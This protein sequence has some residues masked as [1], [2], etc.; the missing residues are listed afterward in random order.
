MILL[1][2]ARDA[3]LPL[4]NKQTLP[5]WEGLIPGWTDPAW[6]SPGWRDF[7]TPCCH[8]QPWKSFPKLPKMDFRIHMYTDVSRKELLQGL[9]PL[10]YHITMTYFHI[11]FKTLNIMFFPARF[12]I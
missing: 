4:L 11:I 2:L 7:P 8:F 6:I 3:R 12:S 1:G 10:V 5:P 9:A